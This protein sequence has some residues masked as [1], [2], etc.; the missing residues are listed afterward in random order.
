MVHFSLRFL[1]VALCLVVLL[2]GLATAP[3]LAA[4]P[5][6]TPALDAALDY[7]SPTPTVDSSGISITVQQAPP[8][9]DRRGVVEFNIEQIPDDAIISS[10]TLTLKITLMTSG[11]GVLPVV[12]VRGYSGTGSLD[13]GILDA[14]SAAVVVGQSDPIANLGLV[15][16]NLDAAFVQSLLTQTNYL[17][18]LL[19]NETNTHQAG[20]LTSEGHNLGLGAAPALVINYVPEPATLALLLL[21]TP[22]LLRRR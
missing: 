3:A 15:S 9:L 21:A 1:P 7:A 17:G 10:A 18:L 12:T 16:I 8:S 4:S 6:L 19:R 14:L 2:A 22:A 5:T 11:S 20:F 13:P